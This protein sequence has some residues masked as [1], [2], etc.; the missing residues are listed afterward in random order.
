MPNTLSQKTG[1]CSGNAGRHQ[2]LCHAPR[3]QNA[4]Q[5]LVAVMMVSLQNGSD[6]DVTEPDAHKH[7]VET[8][9][10]RQIHC[11]QTDAHLKGSLIPRAAAGGGEDVSKWCHQDFT[12]TRPGNSVTE[13]WKLT[14]NSSSF[15][16]FKTSSAAKKVL[17]FSH[18]CFIYFIQMTL[19]IIIHQNTL[20]ESPAILCCHTILQGDLD[21]LVVDV[22]PLLKGKGAS[23]V[24]YAEKL[25]F[26]VD[27]LSSE[28][29]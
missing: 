1:E 14:S 11:V 20:D 6:W 26:C 15:Y 21:D 29:P 17:S 7:M 5:T 23:L 18:G 28:K 3:P 12:E 24:M 22:R 10:Q 19:V 9:G 4:A 16:M 2:A 13:R 27:S 8:W 25:H